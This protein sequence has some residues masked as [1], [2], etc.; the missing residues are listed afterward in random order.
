MLRSEEQKNLNFEVV[1]NL[2]LLLTLENKTY[3]DPEV[4][5]RPPIYAEVTTGRV[6]ISALFP[7]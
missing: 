6:N 7:E 1:L 3:L 4:V 5:P 2:P